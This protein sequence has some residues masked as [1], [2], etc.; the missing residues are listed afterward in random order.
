MKAVGDD[1]LVAAARTLAGLREGH[2]VRAAIDVVLRQ[3]QV[4]LL[5]EIGNENNPETKCLQLGAQL[6]GTQK[7]EG[8]FTYVEGLKFGADGEVEH[9]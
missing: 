3:V 2:P 8:A 9:E 6:A 7:I 5:D 1:E 4:E